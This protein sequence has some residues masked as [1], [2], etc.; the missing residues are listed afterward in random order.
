MAISQM[1]LKRL[2]ALIASGQEYRFYSWSCWLHTRAEVLKLDHYE[3][4]RCKAKG[5]YSRAVLVHHVKHLKDRPDLALSIYD[6]DT[7]ERQLVS[8][9]FECHR[10][11]H[12][13]M[14]HAH[15]SKP[16]FSTRE[17]WD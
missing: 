17:R 6:E 2:I 8:L 10:A 12:P 5:R 14:Q 15:P 13:E 9:C 3:C 7:G 11:E 16:R 1:F 4:Q